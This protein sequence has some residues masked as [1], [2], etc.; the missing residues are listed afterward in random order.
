MH[1][2][3]RAGVANVLGKLRTAGMATLDRPDDEYDWGLAIGH[4]ETRLLDLTAAF[5]TFGRGGRAR[6]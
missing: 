4:A 1:V 3:Q 6:D 2:L 5:T